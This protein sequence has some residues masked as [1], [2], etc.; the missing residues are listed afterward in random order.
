VTSFTANGSG[1][2]IFAVQIQAKKR[3]RPADKIWQ[4]ATIQTLRAFTSNHH[5]ARR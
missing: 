1:K 3:P 4:W 5:C 2:R